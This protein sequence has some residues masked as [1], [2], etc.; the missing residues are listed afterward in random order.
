MTPKDEYEAKRHEQRVEAA[1]FEARQK[2][3]EEMPMKVFALFERLV[4]A[5]EN[6]SSEIEQVRLTLEMMPEELVDR[7]NKTPVGSARYGD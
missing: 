3:D 5:A 2:L 7:F 4:K 1:M 6:I